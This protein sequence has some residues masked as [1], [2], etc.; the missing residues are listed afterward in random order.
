[1]KWKGEWMN[2]ES[3]ELDYICC[4]LLTMRKHTYV[5]TIAYTQAPVEVIQVVKIATD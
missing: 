5:L 2:D 3:I 1:M 4:I